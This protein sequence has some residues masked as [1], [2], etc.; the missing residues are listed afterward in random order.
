MLPY[1]I[2]FVED[3]V[4]PL[5]DPLRNIFGA[6]DAAPALSAFAEKTGAPN[7][8]RDIGMK[9]EDLGRAADLAMAAA[10]W[11]PRPLIRDEILELLRAAWA[12]NNGPLRS[13]F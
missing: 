13:G 10:N 9:Q 8:L 1:T 6:A 11:S 7:A 12:G 5:L 2:A 3:S 4:G